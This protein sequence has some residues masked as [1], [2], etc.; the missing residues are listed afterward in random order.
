MSLEDPLIF[1]IK[2]W[3]VGVL[4]Y[5]TLSFSVSL[6]GN[7]SDNS[8]VCSRVVNTHSYLMSDEHQHIC[9]VD[10]TDSAILLTDHNGKYT[11]TFHQSTSP[12]WFLGSALGFS[13][14]IF[15]LM[16][17][18]GYTQE[19][20]QPLA[21]ALLA[22]KLDALILVSLWTSIATL[23]ILYA[24]LLVVGLVII[25]FFTFIFNATALED[26]NGE[27]RWKWVWLAVLTS[28]LETVKFGQLPYQILS[29]LVLLLL[30]LAK[31]YSVSK[32]RNN[33]NEDRMFAVLFI[34]WLLFNSPWVCFPFN[35][36]KI[37]P[38]THI[39]LA[40]PISALLS[41]VNGY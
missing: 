14:F 11:L 20:L 22:G 36:F 38:P 13:F 18:G 7:R 32:L 23:E 25:G 5:T 30:Q 17:R 21:V 4:E 2:I 16:I 19:R 29:S 33:N 1:T 24:V 8:L 9:S 10:I 34:L 39:L 40:K 41:F 27:I 35:F 26:Q 3:R 37:Q 15:C 31:K 12:L 6:Q 28:L